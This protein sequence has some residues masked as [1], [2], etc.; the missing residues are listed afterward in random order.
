MKKS[1]FII[2]F[3]FIATM[4]F[5]ITSNAQPTKKFNFGFSVGTNYS[6]LQSKV[7]L[8]D[9]FTIDNGFGFQL[10]VLMDYNL[11]SHFVISPKVEL[12]F[13]QSTIALKQNTLHD[14]YQVF[15]ASLDL[16]TH[17]KYR[18]GNGKITPNVFIGPH[19]KIPL[20]FEELASTQ[21]KTNLDFAIDFGVGFDW[22]LKYFTL[23]PEV[24]YSL[25]MLNVNGDPSFQK[26]NF[27]QIAFMI[28]FKS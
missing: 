9:Y 7:N 23:A 27:N 19:I 28:Q 16:M 22:K 3:V 12:G 2:S 21:Y 25:G 20:Y 18:F 24:R 4:L 11:N 5:A 8:P 10:G 1:T 6:L 13:N 14:V 17:M 15:P 26:L